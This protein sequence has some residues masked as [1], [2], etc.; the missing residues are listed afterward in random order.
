VIRKRGR[1]RPDARN[2]SDN[3][4]RGKAQGRIVSPAQRAPGRRTADGSEAQK[5]TPSHPRPL[6]FADLVFSTGDRSPRRKST[7]ADREART[8]RGPGP[9]EMSNAMI[10]DENAIIEPRRLCGACVSTRPAGSNLRRDRTP[11]APSGDERGKTCIARPGTLGSNRVAERLAKKARLANDPSRAAD[12]Q[13]RRSSGPGRWR[14]CQARVHQPNGLVRRTSGSVP[15]VAPARTIEDLRH[16]AGQQAVYPPPRTVGC[17]M[18]TRER[19]IRLERPG[20]R[21]RHPSIIATRPLQ[22]KTAGAT[23]I[24]PA[25]SYSTSAGRCRR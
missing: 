18:P 9:A 4:A 21:V 3:P 14:A 23:L 11:G 24:S 12:L 20:P 6:A 17:L 2:V 25:G 15:P 22:R 1:A 7:G 8:A 10:A 19:P 13:R 16:E 5:L